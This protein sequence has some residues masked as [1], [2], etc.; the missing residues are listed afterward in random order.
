MS[1]KIQLIGCA[2]LKSR[3]CSHGHVCCSQ[4][5]SP[6]NFPVLGFRKLSLSR[7]GYSILQLGVSSF[8]PEQL[9]RGDP[10]CPQELFTVVGS[11]QYRS[12]APPACTLS[13]NWDRRCHMRRYH[14]LLSW[15]TPPPPQCDYAMQNTNILT[16]Q[17]SMPRKLELGRMVNTTG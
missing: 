8:I 9:D 13:T 2:Q 16:I 17:A 10:V 1:Q 3:N 4:C 6:S 14:I 5:F 12:L 15:D 7:L 11:T